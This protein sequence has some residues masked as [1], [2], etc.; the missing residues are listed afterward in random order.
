[1][2]QSARGI[3]LLEAGEILL[4]GKSKPTKLYAIAGDEKLA[5]THEFIELSRL[6]QRLLAAIASRD[7]KESTAA[8]TACRA[9]AGRELHGLYDLFAGRIDNGEFRADLR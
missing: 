2:A 4:K 1:L 3:A 5:A 7:V 6:H 8:L 9:L